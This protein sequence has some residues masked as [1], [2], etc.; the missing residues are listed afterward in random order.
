MKS[1]RRFGPCTDACSQGNHVWF[2]CRRTRRDEELG[3]DWTEVQYEILTS[4]WN[5]T[6]HQRTRENSKGFRF[7][8]GRL[9]FWSTLSMNVSCPSIAWNTWL[10]MKPS[11][12]CYLRSLK[13]MV[14]LQR[15]L[16]SWLARNPCHVTFCFSKSKKS[17]QNGRRHYYYPH[18]SL[19]ITLSAVDSLMKLIVYNCMTMYLR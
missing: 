3:N 1:A 19:N 7:S 16:N 15:V 9:L 12:L 13:W 14:I 2:P 8:M 18:R 5:G 11:R 4:T 6:S 10:W 17:M